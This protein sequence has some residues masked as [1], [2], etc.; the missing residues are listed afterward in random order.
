MD[1]LKFLQKICAKTCSPKKGTLP[2]K[3]HVWATPLL[4]SEHEFL[5]AS[6]ENYIVLF[7]VILDW[8]KGRKD[9]NFEISVFDIS[10]GLCTA[11]FFIGEVAISI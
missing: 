6:A 10:A 5:A 2:R 8:F 11:S 9:W 7:R 1:D 3:F 4:I